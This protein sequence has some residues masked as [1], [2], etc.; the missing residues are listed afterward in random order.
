MIN[1]NRFRH[2][3]DFGFVA[4]DIAYTV[5]EDTGIYTVVATNGVGEDSIS[6]QLTV[7]EKSGSVYMYCLF[8][9]FKML[10]LL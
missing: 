3:A 4:L 2:T 9:T 10:Y 1:S 5:P 6:A 8:Y 7:Q